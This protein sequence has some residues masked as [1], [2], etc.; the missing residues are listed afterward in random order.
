MAQLLFSSLHDL[1]SDLDKGIPLPSPVMETTC[2]FASLLLWHTGLPMRIYG[3]YHL[4]V[5]N[6]NK[7]L[8]FFNNQHTSVVFVDYE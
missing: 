5:N 6:Q 3:L 7:F 8:G 1:F 4:S 2:L